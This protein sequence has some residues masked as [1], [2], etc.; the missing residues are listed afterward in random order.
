MKR[1]NRDPIERRRL[2][3][4][5]LTGGSARANELQTISGRSRSLG[6][7]ALGAIAVGTVAIGAL[8][9]SRLVI[10]RAR[11]RRLEIDDL[12]VRRLQITEDFKAPGIADPKAP[13]PSSAAQNK[14]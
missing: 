1:R 11:I 4:A 7:L 12:I 3:E 5:V 13:P 9:I 2:R 8:A 14:G 6:A 10:G